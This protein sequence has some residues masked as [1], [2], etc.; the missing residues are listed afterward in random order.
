MSQNWIAFGLAGLCLVVL[1]SQDASALG[2]VGAFRA[3]AEVQTPRVNVSFWA[4]PFPH[5]YRGW[6][7]CIRYERFETE[8]GPVFRRISVCGYS[9]HHYSSVLSVKD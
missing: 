3:P 2:P 6:G 1:G 5:G 8:L 7:P 9:R 4:E